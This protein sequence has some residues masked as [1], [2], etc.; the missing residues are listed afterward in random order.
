MN[1]RIYDPLLGRFLSGDL[2]VQNPSSLQ[3]FNRYSYVQNNP[4]TLT[5]PTGFAS[6]S[7]DE[8]WI[9]RLKAEAAARQAN[10]ESGRT[11]LYT[12]GNNEAQTADNEATS[13]AD[14]AQPAATPKVTCVDAADV[15]NR[16][17]DRVNRSIWDD[18]R[19][20]N[21]GENDGA[22]NNPAKEAGGQ[23]A[24]DRT[25]LVLGTTGTVAGAT[26]LLADAKEAANVAKFAKGAGGALFGV[27]V[28]VDVVGV[29]NG[30]TTVLKASENTAVGG[31][32][33]WVGGPWGFAIGAAY[34]VVDTA[35]PDLV[36]SFNRQLQN[37]PQLRLPPL[38]EGT[39]PLP[40]YVIPVG[41]GIAV[42]D[43]A[44]FMG[45]PR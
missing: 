38:Y 37:P 14:R 42:F 41:D 2:I 30:N 39:G 13:A 22:P 45:E 26:E 23:K 10:L 35:C 20:T 25:T 12:S 4:L 31:L 8:E 19:Y 24:Y 1:G 40:N 7:E 5:D 44:A 16:D 11:C 3:S 33:L 6:T 17:G 21:P 32:A 9:N 43:E 34:F 36:P 15:K 18:P 27:G 29:A 28:V